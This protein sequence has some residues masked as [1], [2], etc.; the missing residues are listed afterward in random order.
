MRRDSSSA[1]KVQRV[2]AGTSAQSYYEEQRRAWIRRNRRV[3]RILDCIVAITIVT[4]FVLWRTWAPSAWYGGLVAGAV[5]CFDLAV[6]L[7]PPTWIEQWQSG[8]FGEQRTSR[9][10]SRLGDEWLVLH[11]LRRSNGTNIDHVIVGPPGVYLLDSKNIGTEV[12]VEGDELIVF[13]PDGRQRYRNRT[14]AGK[15]RGAAAVLSQALT[16]AQAGCWVHAVLV[17]WG[18]MPEQHVPATNLDWVAG[19][20]LVDWLSH[21]P[22]DRNPDRLPRVKTVLTSG[23]LDL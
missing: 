23:T 5:L 7:N 18:D 17:V 11:D 9:E 3:F 21:L 8:A 15:A 1:D 20:N 13:R 4:S 16:T 2:K 22:L 10:L 12:R 14:A 19:L 6:R